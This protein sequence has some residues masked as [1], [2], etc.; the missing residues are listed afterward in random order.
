MV[1]Y[2]AQLP[3]SYFISN[4]KETKQG[5]KTFDAYVITSNGVNYRIMSAE[6]F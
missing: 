6:N 4:G 5:K 2:H 3:F 1:L